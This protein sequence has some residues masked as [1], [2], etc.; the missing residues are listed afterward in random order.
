M[1]VH[2]LHFYFNIRIASEWRSFL[3][4]YIPTT[5]FGILP[6]KFYVHAILLTKALRILLADCI[7]DDD[8]QLAEKL[9]K[10][11]CVLY[12]EY[13]GKR[14]VLRFHNINIPFI[15]RN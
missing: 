15:N 12:E 13:Y 8:L 2:V 6:N 14:S 11:F 3:L 7:N 5:L 9:L 1:Y 4:Y 10:Q